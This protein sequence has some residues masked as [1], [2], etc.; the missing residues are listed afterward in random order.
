ML[1]HV[2]SSEGRRYTILMKRMTTTIFSGNKAEVW[3]SA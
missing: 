3:A 2:C 1:C